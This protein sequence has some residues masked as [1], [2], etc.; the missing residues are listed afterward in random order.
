MPVNS[1]NS[2]ARLVDAMPEAFVSN[3]KISNE[4]SR[5]VADKQLRKLA[6]RLYTRN[7][8]DSPESIVRRNL[9]AIVAGYFPG[10]VVA[11]RTALE[12]KPA[13][14]GSVCLITPHG[15]DV[16]LPGVVLRPRR[17]APPQEDDRPFMN[18]RLH[19]SSS[20][21]AYLDNL[22]PSRARG[23]RLPRTLSRAKIEEHLDRMMAAAG[24]DGCNRL[25]DEARQTAEIIG[26]AQQQVELDRIIGAL[27]GTR[28]MRLTAAPARARAEGRPYD[29]KRVA[30]FEDLFAAL[31]QTPAPSRA[32]R[33]RDGIGNATLA[34]FD[35]YFS[36]YIEGTEF[37][38]EEAA[39]IV[40]QGRI[41][42]QRSADAHDIL[43]VWRI[44]SD[45]AEMRRVP[46]TADGLVALLRHRHAAAL[47]GR[48]EALP[49]QFKSMA[50]RAG[51][52]IFVVPDAVL[53]TLNRG[54]EIYRGLEFAFHRAAFMHFVISETH[55]FADGNGRIARIMMNAELVSANEER[56]V[57]PTIYRNNYIAAQRSLSAGHSAEPLV[58]MLQF[59]WRWTV[60]MDWAGLDATKEQLRACN[61]F[62]DEETA[63]RKGVRL[64]L[65]PDNTPNR[66][67]RK[68]NEDELALTP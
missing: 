40:F 18:Q 44:V 47:G 34:F 9:W 1:E 7:F 59:A 43:G 3:T 49:G 45:A 20:A 2:P 27:A 50:N 31:R 21:R 68:G 13:A 16:E 61:A 14:D 17:G 56:I 65:P 67:V 53:G 48:P 46:E 19:L 23:G 66:K 35:A 57:I 32:P 8:E 24:I 4:V 12:L 42:Q 55:P 51:A 30:L 11:D 25:R 29:P 5:R 63:E 36:N 6:T 41:P 26:R 62:E 60:A 64:Q 54:F 39:S 28:E 58:R 38:V 22:R 10:A 37:E 15:A 52:T 33:A